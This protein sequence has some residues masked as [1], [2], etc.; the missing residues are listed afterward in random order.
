[1]A[2]PTFYELRA[3]TANG[4]TKGV[5][6]RKRADAGVLDIFFVD[7]PSNDF[8][9]YFYHGPVNG[10]LIKGVYF[11]DRPTPFSDAAQQFQREKEFWYSWQRENR[12]GVVKLK[13]Q[14]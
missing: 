14:S 2:D 13:D 4:R 9:G 7:L 8:S 5:L 3:R 1:V 11:D 6:V 10:R 12:Q